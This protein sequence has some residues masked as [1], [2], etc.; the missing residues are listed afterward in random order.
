MH[1]IV[2][3]EYTDDSGLKDEVGTMDGLIFHRHSH[4]VTRSD[5]V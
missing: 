3:Y 2:M 1:E 4:Y 5:Q